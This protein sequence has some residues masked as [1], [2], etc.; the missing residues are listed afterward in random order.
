MTGKA[1][2][3]LT[4]GC[5]QCHDHKFDPIPTKDYYALLG[6]FQSTQLKEYPL[7][8]KDVVEKYDKQADEIK[9]LKKKLTDFRDRQTRQLAEILAEQTANYILAAWHVL[10][11]KHRTPS[12]VAAEQKLD[13]E[14]LQRS[15]RYL[16]KKEHTH[17][18]LDTW[19]RLRKENTAEEAAVIA[20]AREFQAQL[21]AV[22]DEIRSIEE[23]NLATLGGAEGNPALAKVVLLPYPRGKYVF[24][25]EIFGDSRTGFSNDKSERVLQYKGEA[26]DRFLEGEWKSYAAGLAAE[27]QRKQAELPAKYPFLHV[28]EDVEKPKNV[29]VH[30]RGNPENLGEEAPRAFLS[31]LSDGNP[32][33]FT[34]G[35]GRLELAE[36]IANASNPLTARVMVNRIWAHHVG[37]GI[38]RTPSGF[39]QL[40]DRPTHPELLD[41]LASRFVENGWSIKA[42]HREIMLSSTYALGADTPEANT[43]KDPG[44]RFCW[45]ANVRRLDIEALRDSVLAVSGQLDKTLGG[46]ARPIGDERNLQRTVYSFVS[47]RKLDNTLAIFDFPN[48]NDTAEKRIATNTPLQRLF[49]LNSTFMTQ[50]AQKFADR[51]ATEA[52]DDSTAR[53]VRAYRLAFGRTPSAEEIQW[54]REYLAGGEGW[55]QYLQA[56]LA[57][58][59]FLYTN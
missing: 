49:L 9:A 38:V 57:S 33:P 17:K 52:G 24:W 35:S 46:Q 28:I 18:Y 42:M 34:N 8:P 20:V 10:G 54:G 45:R 59:E 41:Y 11:P 31:I 53:L 30:I 22:H 19:Q 12:E 7:A 4:V 51:V 23:K 25:S 13:T 37:D 26:I 58:N 27:V 14:T 55:P 56:I 47:R 40:G 44:N 21:L 32:R 16:E 6:V 36:A 43:K 29:K 3:G 48:A 1:F 5:A 2:L 15:I 50:Q 39:G